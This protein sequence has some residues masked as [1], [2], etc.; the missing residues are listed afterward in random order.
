MLAT[1]DLHATIWPVSYLSGEPRE[2]IGLAALSQNIEKARVENPN[3]LLFDN[4]DFLQGTSLADISADEIAKDKTAQHPM[5]TAMNALNFDAGTLG[6]HDFN[7]GLTVLRRCLSQSDFPFVTSNIQCL[8]PTVPAL[9][10]RTLILTRDISDT[11]G[12]P[13]SLRIGVFGATPPQT[14][15]WEQN[16]LGT[17]WIAQDILEASRQ[18][19]ADLQSAGVDL[20]IGLIHSGI[21]PQTPPAF[22]ENMSL[23]V[24]GLD[25]VDALIAGHSHQRFPSDELAHQCGLNVSAGLFNDTPA[26]LPG[27]SGSDLGVLDLTIEQH[28]N[29]WKVSKSNSS[30]RSCLPLSLEAP[31]EIGPVPAKILSLTQRAHEKTESVAARHVGY[32]EQRL[33]GLFS[34]VARSGSQDL[35]AEALLWRAKQLLINAGVK[36]HPVLAATSPFSAGGLAGPHAFSSIPRGPLELRHLTQLYPFPNQLSVL[37]VTGKILKLWIERAVSGFHRLDPQVGPSLLLN[38]DAACYNFDTIHGLSYEIDLSQDAL[39]DPMGAPV[40]TSGKGRLRAVSYEGKPL[41]D[42]DEFY[43][44]TNSYRA[45]CGGGFGM[46][47]DARPVISGTGPLCNEITN[48]VEEAHTLA[49]DTPPTWHFSPLGALAYFDSH[50]GAVEADVPKD[51]PRMERLG[52]QENGYCRF[53]VHI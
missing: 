22:S 49:F 13:Q 40:S 7:Y 31:D 6:N 34:P 50:P 41:Q 39:F 8:D 44:A 15:Q 5:I 48:F 27:A 1:T 14:I 18:A 38:S 43:V 20:I 4:G 51:G 36:T 45:A 37:W 32:N 23:A 24:A 29:S 28:G 33:H 11:S 2:C 42:T 35:M 12:V 21:G 46:L 25:G 53:L 47:L 3:C 19:V 52:L 26:V 10:P 30:L 9:T 17:R 16:H